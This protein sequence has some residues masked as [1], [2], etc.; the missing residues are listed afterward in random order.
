MN[1]DNPA[2]K[3]AVACAGKARCIQH[4][5]EVILLGKF[6]DALDEVA[7]GLAIAGDNLP[8]RMTVNENAS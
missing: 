5:L 6:A 2:G 8:A 3:I 1:G 7:I 4:G